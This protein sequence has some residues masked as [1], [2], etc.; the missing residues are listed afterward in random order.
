MNWGNG[1]CESVFLGVQICTE[2]S[3][4]QGKSCHA[5]NLHRQYHGWSPDHLSWGNTDHQ[6]SRERDCELPTRAMYWG[7][8]SEFCVSAMSGVVSMSNKLR[9]TQLRGSRQSLSPFST[10]DCFDI[11]IEGTGSLSCSWNHIGWGLGGQGGCL[12]YHPQNILMEFLSISVAC[13]PFPPTVRFSGFWAF[14]DLT[15]SWAC[16]NLW[17]LRLVVGRAQA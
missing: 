11:V 15:Q 12:R 16:L 7:T 1:G 3:Q 14:L 6:S 2:H 5:A 8:S 4:L 17:M 13:Q 10:K 9:N